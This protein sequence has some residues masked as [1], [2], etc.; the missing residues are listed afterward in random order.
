M[1]IGGVV[2]SGFGGTIIALIFAIVT[3]PTIAIAGGAFVAFILTRQ[4]SVQR[5]YDSVGT[6][7]FISL[8]ILAFLFPLLPE[9][10][11]Q[12]L[13]LI[14]GVFGIL[15]GLI[16]ISKR[17]IGY[18]L[19]IL[20]KRLSLGQNGL[21]LYKAA[22]SI[23][24]TIILVWSIIKLK[25]R[26]VKTGIVG[27][28]T[29]LGLTFNILGYFVNLPWILEAGI[30]LTTIIFIGG[31]ITGFHVLTS[32]YEVLAIRKDPLVQT[33]AEHSKNISSS[34]IIKSQN[35]A[36]SSS[37]RSMDAVSSKSSEISQKMTERPQDTGKI[38]L[39]GRKI[40]ATILGVKSERSQS[41]PNST[42]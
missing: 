13:Q 23:I 21:S 42:S 40:M 22:S 36:K 18:L 28:A 6:I 39:I 20:A 3:L 5:H 29:P 8:S 9:A 10:F 15:S 34:T 16:I 25:Y 2:L 7:Y 12:M 32:W 27:V 11:N 19:K 41:D 37:E 4:Y 38:N 26:I 35:V 30:D 31:L 17:T 24:G 14:L 1:R 33:L